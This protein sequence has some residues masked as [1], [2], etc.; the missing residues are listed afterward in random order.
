M[1]RAPT[2]DLRTSDQ[3]RRRI[4]GTE[5]KK[6]C[7]SPD[8][9]AQSPSTGRVGAKP[10]INNNIYDMDVARCGSAMPEDR[11]GALSPQVILAQQRPRALERHLRFRRQAAARR[12]SAVA[13]GSGPPRLSA[14]IWGL[15]ATR[16]VLGGK[17]QFANYYV[18]FLNAA[19]LGPV[20]EADTRL[21]IWPCPLPYPSAGRRDPDGQRIRRPARWAE[22]RRRLT[23]LVV[24]ALNFVH[25]GFRPWL[26]PVLRRPRRLTHLQQEHVE[27]LETLINRWGHIEVP[28]LKVGRKGHDMHQ[29]VNALFAHSKVVGSDLMSYSSSSR[30]VPGVPERGFLEP[31]AARLGFPSRPEGCP[32][33]DFLGPYMR[34]VYEEPQVLRGGP[35]RQAT[36]DRPRFR[37]SV[38][39][40]VQV[41]EKWA[42][43]DRFRV[44]PARGVRKEEVSQVAGVFKT[45]EEDRQI[46]DERGPNSLEDKLVEGSSRHLPSGPLLLDAHLRPD[47]QMIVGTKDRKSF[48]HQFEVSDARACRTPVGLPIRGE[49]LRHIPGCGGLDP[50]ALYFGCFRGLGMGDHIA[51]DAALEGH[52][53]L[54]QEAGA[55][56]DEVWVRGDRPVPGGDVLAEVIIDDLVVLAKVPRHSRPS[57]LP[58]A[59]RPDLGL[60]AKADAGYAKGRMP[61]AP[62]KDVEGRSC[63]VA[64][65]IEIDGSRGFGGSPRDRLLPMAYLTLQASRLPEITLEFADIL[66]GSWTSAFLARRPLLSIFHHVYGLRGDRRR[67]GVR[68]SRRAAAELAVASI[69]A[70]LAVADLRAPYSSALFATDASPTGGGITVIDNALAPDT[71]DLLWRHRERKGGYSRLEVPEVAAAIAY[72][73]D[74]DLAADFG[75]EDW[76]RAKVLDPSRPVAQR[77][78][79]LPLFEPDPVLLEQLY[80]LDARVGPVVSRARSPF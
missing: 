71:A 1:R 20:Q 63:H 80:G 4:L 10:I 67:E 19:S 60:F 58:P 9:P 72:G 7:R 46:L 33:G 54:L 23:N 76:A 21:A 74:V 77:W 56:P 29:F 17:S 51:V 6:S 50:R 45:I 14:T 37:G 62:E 18:A 59:L 55:L 66:T 49:L 30:L 53:A 8:R 52:E 43:V 3:I 78:D 57:A 26:P 35:V 27:W 28:D 34:S 42:Q 65:G 5:P 12:R 79:I 64:G 32:L 73:F 40:L 15:S 61:G 25:N 39:N 70:P 44:I 31:D 16:L 68:L 24:G 2:V 48:Y 36:R 11:P 13:A 47:Q 38:S 69:L 22:A 75:C 41:F